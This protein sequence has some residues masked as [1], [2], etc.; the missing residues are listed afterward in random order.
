MILLLALQAIHLGDPL[1]VPRTSVVP[2][3]DVVV[4]YLDDVGARTFELMRAAN[5]LPNM[6]ALADQGTEFTNGYGQPMC[7]P[8]RWSFYLSDWEGGNAGFACH[9]NTDGTGPGA[10]PET[11]SHG[12]MSLPKAMEGA[13]YTTA[14]FGRWGLGTWT[15]D[16]GGNTVYALTP[17]L[18]GFQMWH[19]GLP[20][21]VDRCGGSSYTDWLRADQGVVFYET[22]YHTSV[23]RAEFEYVWQNTEGPRFF[24]VAFQAAHKPFHFPPTSAM[25]PGW[26]SS[27]LFGNRA[28]YEAV[29][30]SAD[31]ALG[32]MLAVIDLETTL[33]I[34]TADNG[35]P[36]EVPPAGYNQNKVKFS[37][38]DGGVRVPFIV[39]GCGF[40]EGAV[41][42]Q[43]VSL[44]DIMPTLG[45][46]AGVC[47]PQGDGQSF[48]PALDEMPLE[49]TWVY[50]QGNPNDRAVMGVL[51]GLEWKLRLE[52]DSDEW[53]YD[54][55]ADPFESSPIDADASGY[56]DVALW[57]RAALSEAQ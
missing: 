8:S 53:L 27:G 30:E 50:M 42:T 46:L 21:G 32:Q 33:V 43:P 22:Q 51:D 40:P 34:L 7:A 41:S 56:E 49:R 37:T 23:L 44:V 55:A 20:D 38:F 47:V 57:A 17:N 5:R 15:D 31:Y 26:S 35:D 9:P 10:E 54:L 45:D 12:L 48:L 1:P 24:V 29:V 52:P 18:W 11:L 13:G 4:F 14:L 25:P 36:E 39:A 6:D 19:A 16:P 2:T 3:P 28:K